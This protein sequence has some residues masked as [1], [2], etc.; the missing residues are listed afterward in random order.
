[1]TV[2]NGIN[3]WLELLGISS[4]ALLLSNTF[5]ASIFHFVTIQM[6]LKQDK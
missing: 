2:Q 3:V 1:M 5:L 6:F 4:S